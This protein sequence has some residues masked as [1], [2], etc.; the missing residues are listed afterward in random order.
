MKNRL[1]DRDAPESPIQIGL[2]DAIRERRSVHYFKPG[3]RI[4]PSQW[5]MLFDLASLSPSSFNFQPWEF[6]LVEDEARRR[7]LHPL[8]MNQQQIL[9]CA[10]VIGVIGDKDPHRR[11]RQILQQFVDNGYFDG[12]TRDAY[13]GA[14]DV[15]YP[16][17]GRRIEH[18][19]GGAS[20]AA[21]TLMLAAH[22]MGLATAPIIGF[23]V[24]AVTSFLAVP[25]G[26]MVVMLIA[27]GH[28]ANRELPRQQ[29][30]PFHDIVHREHF[31]DGRA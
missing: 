9:D 1:Q 29:R 6:V 18:A 14:V 31:N 28:S 27:I 30:R 25:S 15:L 4:A 23:D 24:Q 7:A 21:M 16:D 20:L 5:R 10:A 3:G 2:E 22:G 8:C 17:E 12:A 13:L 11:D 26:Y 19:V